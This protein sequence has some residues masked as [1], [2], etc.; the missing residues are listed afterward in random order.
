MTTKFFS[1]SL[2]LLLIVLFSGCSKT[3]EATGEVGTNYLKVKIDGKEKSFS[4]VSARWVDAG[5]FLEVSG[6]DSGNEWVTFTVMSESSRVPAGEYS[7][8]DASNFTI[9]S[10]YSILKDN[11]QV[12]FAAT[13]GTLAPEDAF[14]LKIDKIDNVSVKG[15]FSAA[16]V[17]VEGL[18]TLGTVT[19]TEGEFQSAVKPN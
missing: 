10:I 2:V 16:L 5:N 13:R 6:T 7:L 18:N 4:D 12:N 14:V 15:S 17:R 3:D 9:V 19:L 1:A 11:A 8:D